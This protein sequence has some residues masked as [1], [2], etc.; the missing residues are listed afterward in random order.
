VQAGCDVSIKNSGGLTGQQC[1]EQKGNTAVLTRLHRFTQPHHQQAA[2]PG[3]GPPTSSDSG[4]QEDVAAAATAGDVAELSRWLDSGADPN[5]LLQLGTRQKRAGQSQQL[6][7]LI[8]A[9]KANRVPAIK[10]LLERGADPD[11][12]VRPNADKFDGVLTALRSAAAGGHLEPARLL[13]DAGADRARSHCRLLPLNRFIPDLL[14]YLVTL[15]LKRQCDRTLGADPRLPV[16]GNGTPLMTAAW[17][18]RLEMLQLLLARGVDPN[19]VCESIGYTALHNACLT[20]LSTRYPRR[21]ADCVE[22]LVRAGCDVDAED[23]KGRTGKQLAEEEGRTEVLARLAALETEQ[24]DGEDRRRLPPPAPPR[25]ALRRRQLVD[26]LLR[27][28]LAREAAAATDIVRKTPSWPRTWADF[29][30]F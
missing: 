1:A 17:C 20:P 29:S 27:G 25:P 28:K 24:G 8:L 11:L 12:I 21:V 26:K 4:A 30:L 14:T 16:D 5:S 15:F 7:A 18:G 23:R 10:L 22:V 13:L 2:E 6:S 19:A 9:V 3:L